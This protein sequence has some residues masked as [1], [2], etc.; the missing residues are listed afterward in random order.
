[1]KSWWSEFAQINEIDRFESELAAA[2][3][4]LARDV[5]EKSGE[6]AALGFVVQMARCHL[7]NIL[8]AAAMGDTSA[9]LDL[10]SF[11]RCG[12]ECCAGGASEV[13]TDGARSRQGGGLQ[14]RQ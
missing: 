10:N 8:I 12:D 3:Q 9:Q 5:G 2:F 14:A 11:R 13:T 7:R 6:D 1:M 4:T